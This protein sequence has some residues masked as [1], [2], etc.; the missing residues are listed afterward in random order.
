MGTGPVSGWVGVRGR[1]VGGE[2]DC[3]KYREG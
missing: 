1:Q 3:G 2:N